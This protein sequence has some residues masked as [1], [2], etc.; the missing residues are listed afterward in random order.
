MISLKKERFEKLG[1]IC[2]Y[3]NVSVVRCHTRSKLLIH[4]GYN[5]IDFKQIWLMT[6]LQDE[7]IKI[8]S[9]VLSEKI[10]VKFTIITKNNSF[11]P[12]STSYIGDLSLLLLHPFTITMNTN[13]L[14]FLHTKI[15]PN[16][17][18]H[19]KKLVSSNLILRK[20]KTSNIL[21]FVSCTSIKHLNTSYWQIHYYKIWLAFFCSN[22][23][24]LTSLVMDD[25]LSVSLGDLKRTPYGT[26]EGLGLST[27]MGSS[28][29]MLGL[30]RSVGV[31]PSLTPVE[32]VLW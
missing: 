24:S 30:S 11:M 9:N 26:P 29:S 21:K 2:L 18:Y 13:N 3:I 31:W 4:V 8:H 15:Q 14:H 12:F 28:S 6:L 20:A 23:A 7:V 1:L 10:I 19:N 25:W 22:T 32:Q 5:F 17:K 27:D 16:N